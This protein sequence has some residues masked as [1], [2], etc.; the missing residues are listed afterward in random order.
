MSAELS[1]VY[2]SASGRALRQHEGRDVAIHVLPPE[3]P[4]LDV[5]EPLRRSVRERGDARDLPRTVVR[6]RLNRLHLDVDWQHERV[7]DRVVLLSS[8][9]VDALAPQPQHGGRS[10]GRVTAEIETNRWLDDFGLAARL[11][12]HFDDEVGAR[13]EAPRQA[14]REQRGDLAGRPAEKMTVRVDGGVREQSFVARSRIL[15]VELAR[16]GRAIDPNVCVMHDGL[17]AGSKFQS[18]DVAHRVDRKGE[19]EHAGHIST[20][21]R[22][23]IRL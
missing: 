13:S 10:F 18:P 22:K 8:R 23:H 2:R 9:D 15:I 7:G 16:R 12:V 3:V 19:H 21:R 20:V 1:N 14:L 11:H 6:V 5:N 4:I 17:I